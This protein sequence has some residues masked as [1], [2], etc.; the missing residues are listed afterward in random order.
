[1]TDQEFLD[2]AEKVLINIEATCDDLNDHSDVDIDNNR[3]GNALTLFF[4]N[5]SQIVINLQKPL[6]E[7]WVASQSGGYH[8]YC[9]K[10]RWQEN[11]EGRELYASLSEFA[12]R[13]TGVSITFQQN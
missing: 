6:H 9:E 8:F 12:S 2:A 4:S 1:M 5:G 11:R 13:Q 7:I 3:Q 10:G